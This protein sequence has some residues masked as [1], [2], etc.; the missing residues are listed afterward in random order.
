MRPDRALAHLH[1]VWTNCGRALRAHAAD[2]AGI[3]DAESVTR[4][5]VERYLTNIGEALVRL[6]QDAPE[7]L[8]RLP[9]APPAISMRNVLVHLYDRIE[10]A[11][12][13]RALTETVAALEARARHVAQELEQDPTYLPQ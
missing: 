11:E 13:E 12:L 7:V 4:A 9:E 8:A 3:W 5:A 1:D 10:P 2:R 6:R